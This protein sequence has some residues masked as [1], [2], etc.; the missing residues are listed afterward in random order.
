MITCHSLDQFRRLVEASNPFLLTENYALIQELTTSISSAFLLLIIL[1]H[2]FIFPKL[3]IHG[4]C[5][6]SY[7]IALFGNWFT[8]M[9]MVIN[10]Y[11]VFVEILQRTWLCTA[12]FTSNLYFRLA[13]FSWMTVMNVDMFRTFRCLKQVSRQGVLGKRK[14]LWRRYVLHSL[15]CWGI[16]GILVAVFVAFNIIIKYPGAK[17]RGLDVAN[18]SCVG[19][20]TVFYINH[21]V[22]IPA[23]MLIIFNIPLMILTTLILFKARREKAKSLQGSESMESG[24]VAD[25]T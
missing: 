15:I 7:S 18:V 8:G 6:L 13:A 2:L 10:E 25:Y 5:I 19:V 17:F 4:L 12:L 14:L 24:K 3:N 11:K 21:V 22:K 9:L 1:F 23:G 16:P 20:W